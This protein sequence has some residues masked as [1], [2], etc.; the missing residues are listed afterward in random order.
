M[1]LENYL[2]TAFPEGFP[3]KISYTGF[4]CDGYHYSYTDNEG[5]EHDLRFD[6]AQRFVHDNITPR[7]MG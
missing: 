6:G 7:R 3:Y 1:L 2:K 5:N 4:I